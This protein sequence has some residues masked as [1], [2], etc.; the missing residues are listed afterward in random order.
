MSILE[1]GRVADEFFMTRGHLHE[2]SDRSELYIGLS[3]QGVMVLETVAGDSQ[4][5]AVEPGEAVYVPGNRVHRSVNVG[6]DR[7]VTLFC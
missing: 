4:V 6:T 5:V 3:G 1:P 7:F 2:I